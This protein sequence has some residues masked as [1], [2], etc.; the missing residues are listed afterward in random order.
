MTPEPL[1]ATEGLVWELANRDPELYQA[2]ANRFSYSLEQEE[3]G[4]KVL[5]FIP[6]DGRDDYEISD[7]QDELEGAKEVCQLHHAAIQLAIAERVKGKDEAL[8]R[9]TMKRHRHCAIGEVDVDRCLTCQKDIRDPIHFRWDE[10]EETDL[11][12]A[13]AALGDF[14]GGAS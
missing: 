3:N 11:A 2:A 1:S 10:S 8:T 7:F 6:I 9:L 13:E 4:W 14:A 5:I 12:F